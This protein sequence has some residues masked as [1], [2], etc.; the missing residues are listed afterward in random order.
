MGDSCIERKV[1]VEKPPLSR[2]RSRTVELPK[3]EKPQIDR[4]RSQSDSCIDDLKKSKYLDYARRMW[5]LVRVN[6]QSTWSVDS[7]AE[8]DPEPAPLIRATT[9]PVRTTES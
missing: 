1:S 4:S 6:R 3:S 5:S 7:A 2:L 8:T 9:E